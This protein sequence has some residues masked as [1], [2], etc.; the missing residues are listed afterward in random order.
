MSISS[1]SRSPSSSSSSSPS[2]DVSITTQ[3]DAL[4]HTY[5]LNGK[6]VLFPQ[7]Q[8]LIAA[9]YPLTSPLFLHFVDDDGDRCRIT[10][11]AELREALRVCGPQLTV[12]LSSSLSPPQSSAA[13]DVASLTRL[14]S[15]SS[16]S[17]PS[18]LLSTHSPSP[19]PTAS[20]LAG[21]VSETYPSIDDFLSSDEEDVWEQARS[22]VRDGAGDGEKGEN[23]GEAQF[24][25]VA[26]DSDDDGDHNDAAAQPQQPHERAAAVELP[27]NSTSPSIPTSSE[28]PLSAQEAHQLLAAELVP[29]VAEEVK[30]DSA[31]AADAEQEV[32]IE[33][34]QHSNDGPS[35]AIAVSRIS[36]AAPVV[37]Q[38]VVQSA[39]NERL[40]AFYGSAVAEQGAAVPAAVAVSAIG[41]EEAG[42]G[43]L[44]AAFFSRPDVV[45]TIT[46][47]SALLSPLLAS[48]SLALF[49]H[50]L[51]VLNPALASD[52]LL[53]YAFSRA[54]VHPRTTCAVCTVS[55]IV[56]TRYSCTDCSE[57][58]C[59]ECKA[60]GVHDARHVLL[61]LQVAP[62]SPAVRV[63]PVA[64][65]RK[66]N[67]GGRPRELSDR[68]LEGG[69]RV[70][71]SLEDR[72]ERLDKALTQYAAE[73]KRMVEDMM[74]GVFP[75]H[76]QRSAA[77]QEHKEP[78][79]CDLRR[80]C[81]S[82]PRP[83][84]PAAE[85]AAVAPAVDVRPE[86]EV[87]GEARPRPQAA[88][89][90]EEQ[91]EAI[92]EMGLIRTAE[93][94]AT[95]RDMLGAN[96]GNTSRTVQWL[97]ENLAVA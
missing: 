71:S 26:L 10:S 78:R 27:T 42:I 74:D 79:S 95:V 32:D 45:R 28:E 40:R 38:E 57:S 83:Q 92:R 24:G 49:L 14:S 19:Q 9:K 97:V 52:P 13:L 31:T 16:A 11:E 34:G 22:Q 20:S 37:D 7:L 70:W 25:V 77:A 15:L 88:G 33:L 81:S 51:A 64:E 94:E 58:L 73:I 66:E 54:A 3:F 17:S 61:P 59:E 56:G 48:Q 89:E 1:S 29:V 53:S 4:C 93:D 85:A 6:G 2:S 39:I 8:Q 68:V 82:S 76:Q 18:P 43:A 5:Q 46:T 60:M 72:I 21:G 47:H 30:G 69:R 80:A 96:K 67:D 90:W 63:V 44:F 12:L 50:E 65:E 91:V 75:S 23:A 41:Y 86:R 36:T 87:M 84:E 35:V 55:P 62:S